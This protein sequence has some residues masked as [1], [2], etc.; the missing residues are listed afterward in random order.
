MSIDPQASGAR[1]LNSPFSPS[2]RDLEKLAGLKRMRVI[3]T[4]LL[5]ASVIVLII[6]KV[7]EHRHPAWGFVAAFAEAAT[8]GA[9]ADWYA[10]VA[11]F[12][13][14]MGVPVPHT[15]IIPKNRDRIAESLGEFVERQFLAPT[16]VERK[17]KEVDFAALVSNWLVE[18]EKSRS[19]TRFAIK[20]VPQMLAK[21]DESGLKAF[22]TRR[23]LEELNRVEVAPLA[24]D[25]LKA[26]TDDG[27]HQDLLDELLKAIDGILSNQE[28]VDQ[29][30]DKIRAELP[31]LFNM[32]KA[33]AYLLK[34]IMGAA[35]S[36]TEEVRDNPEHPL[37]AEFDRFVG[38]FITR[39]HDSPEYAD[40]AERLKRD[41]IARPELRDLASGLWGSLKAYVEADVA[42]PDSKIEGHL[43]HLLVQIG[44][45]LREDPVLSAEVN[46]GFVTALTTFVETQKSGVSRF[47]AD[48]V[49]GWDIQQLIRLIEINIGR[50]LQYIRVNGTVIG[51]LAGLVL[52]TIEVLFRLA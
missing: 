20:L 5:I 48:Q 29:I 28:T 34:R 7:N 15:A 21:A 44:H 40:R 46:A 43:A 13:H 12:K 39:L 1:D 31:S 49:K 37:R 19:L 6:A 22:V 51:G 2:P 38:D 24:A 18:R 8:I 52:H 26:F 23:A 42:A 11:L 3:A 4:G 9:L 17:L 30:R 45:H 10:I 32:F 50:D 36:F 27:R 16:P 41:L 14:P 35:V 33:D 47:I 25:I